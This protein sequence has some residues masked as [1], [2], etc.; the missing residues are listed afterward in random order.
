V[1]KE[2]SGIF[3]RLRGVPTNGRFGVLWGDERELVNSWTEYVRR[4][5]D[6]VAGWGRRTG[7]YDESLG[8]LLNRV[9]EEYEGYFDGVASVL[10]FGDICGKNVMVHE[11]RF[12]GLVDLDAL[13]QGDYLEAV[14]RIK[15][16]WYGA[17]YGTVY[18]EALMDE[19]GLR[20]EQ[21]NIVTMYALLNRIFWACENGIQFNSNTSTDVDWE[22]ARN[23][24]A[25][26]GMIL[27]ELEQ[28]G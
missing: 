26:I 2:V 25:V 19:E 3:R 6:V 5:S 14:G 22:K 11:G 20:D 4:M 9:N 27:T 7:V 16:S 23:D 12:N 1:A 8:R 13:A 28:C 21:R 15:A 17:R 10:Y 18:T 24:R